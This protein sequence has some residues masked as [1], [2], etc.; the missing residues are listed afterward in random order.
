MNETLYLC[1]I[2]NKRWKP[3]SG[4]KRHR[5]NFTQPTRD[6]VADITSP[7]EDT[8]VENNQQQITSRSLNGGNTKKLNL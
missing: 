5:K 7:M 2:C 1:Y 6:D 4:L 3:Q 8:S